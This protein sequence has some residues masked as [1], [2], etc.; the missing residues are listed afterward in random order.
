MTAATTAAVCRHAALTLMLLG[1][2]LAE[3]GGLRIMGAIVA[4]AGIA[5]LGGW[6][7]A[8]YLEWEGP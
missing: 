6:I 8:G 2:M 4:T 3:F 5:A 1:L 7:V